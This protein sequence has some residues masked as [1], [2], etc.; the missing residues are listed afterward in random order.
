L[1]GHSLGGL[2]AEYYAARH[3]DQV[4]GLILEESRPADFTRRCEAARVGACV[5]PAAVMF[6]APLGAQ[7]ERDALAATM[8]DMEAIGPVAG[9]SVLVLS[10]PVSADAAPFD[11]LWSINQDDLASRYA[12]ARHLTASSGGH[13]LHLDKKAWFISSVREFL[14]S[15][16]R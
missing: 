1:V 2:F 16:D 5:A 14:A 3:P 10:R 12:G 4:A 6:F 7:G 8:A 9:K 11:A 15:V 13:Y